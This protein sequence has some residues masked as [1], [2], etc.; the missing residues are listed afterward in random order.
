[1]CET[2]EKCNRRGTFWV[3]SRREIQHPGNSAVGVE[4]FKSGVNIT[5]CPQCLPAA[6][7][8]IGEANRK[9]ANG[10]HLPAS[11]GVIVKQRMPGGSWQ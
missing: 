9:A 11:D 7:R 8:S 4:P 6:I 2:R 5:A 1:M 3:Q 10:V